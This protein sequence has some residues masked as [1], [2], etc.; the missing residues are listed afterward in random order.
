[1]RHVFKTIFTIL[2]GLLLAIPMHVSSASL[3]SDT[4][5][6]ILQS[7]TNLPHESGVSGN[8]E[9][10]CQVI[11]TKAMETLQST[12][13]KVGRNKA[14]YG[15]SLVQAE[16]VPSASL[17]FSTVG[18]VANISDIRSITT[19][20]LDAEKGVWGLSLLKLQANLPDSLPGQNVTFL[21]FGNT[22]IDN[23]SGD[24]STFY[25]TSGIGLP[26]CKEAPKDSIV[27]KSPNHMQVT[28]TANGTKI[29]IA[30]TIVLRA[31]K[32]N[33]MTVAL[34]EGHA[35]VTIPQGSQ[36]LKPGQEL[37]VP[38]GSVTGLVPVAPPSAPIAMPEDMTDE[39]INEMI[40]SAQ[41]LGGDETSTDDALVST[42]I[43]DTQDTKDKSGPKGP[44][45]PK[46]EPKDKPKPPAQ[47][48]G[49]KPP[50]PHNGPK[51]PPPPRP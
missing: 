30:S 7:N 33:K 38:L 15:N 17:K 36:D 34:V 23:I 13:Q 40:A 41:Q 16:P 19:A 20:P 29:T 26:T 39:H 31:E 49:Q 4:R 24:M 37:T 46:R 2:C 21:V 8:A 18:D 9:N 45:D 51:P 42:D 22:L 47:K 6:T 28:F 3:P 25:F 44:K 32:G 48:G 50:A 35:N 10:R 27:V 11:L 1:M 5:L 12:C 14:C 43:P